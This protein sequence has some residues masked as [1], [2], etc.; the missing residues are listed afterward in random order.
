MPRWSTVYVESMKAKEATM[1]E[2]SPAQPSRMTGSL[3][4]P[5]CRRESGGSKGG[6]HLMDQPGR[7]VR[8]EVPGG[9]PPPGRAWRPGIRNHL[10]TGDETKSALEVLKVLPTHKRAEM[11]KDSLICV[12]TQ[13]STL[14]ALHMNKLLACKYCLSCP[15]F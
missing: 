4:P 11:F 3:P 12:L 7:E 9:C 5:S 13:G 6:R 1:Q 15:L 2:R 10:H 8:A 14:G